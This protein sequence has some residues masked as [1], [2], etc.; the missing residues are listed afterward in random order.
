MSVDSEDEYR[1]MAKNAP[2]DSDNDSTT[3]GDTNGFFDDL[4]ALRGDV[5]DDDKAVLE[6]PAKKRKKKHPFREQ[7]PLSP[8][9]N[10]GPRECGLCHSVHG[11]GGCLM[12]Q[13]SANLVEYRK[14]LVNHAED[15]PWDD[16]VRTS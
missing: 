16:R 6:R 15:E 1:D 8:I 5:M 7:R 10:T 11:P 12:T 4:N 13:T 3:T 14:M 2:V 9:H